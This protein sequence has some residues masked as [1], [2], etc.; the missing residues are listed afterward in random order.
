MRNL[1]VMFV[2][3]VCFLF[4][5]KLKWPKNKNFYDVSLIFLVRYFSNSAS[6]C[7]TLHCSKYQDGGR[8]ALLLEW[9]TAGCKRP[10]DELNSCCPV[11][12]HTCYFMNYYLKERTTSLVLTTFNK[13]I[14]MVW[15]FAQFLTVC[16]LKSWQ[17]RRKLL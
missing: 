10:L 13:N 17:G 5:L 9:I 7:D 12:G 1:I 8:E 11:H 16:W 15:W 3:T 2:T 4:L 14:L 6:S